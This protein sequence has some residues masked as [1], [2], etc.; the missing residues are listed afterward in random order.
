[1]M[2]AREMMFAFA[3]VVSI[4]LVIALVNSLLA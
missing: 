2:T 1:M 4:T 3:A